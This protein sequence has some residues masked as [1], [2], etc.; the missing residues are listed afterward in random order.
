MDEWAHSVHL[1][2]GVEKHAGF[3]LRACVCCMAVLNVISV[4]A[5]GS[6]GGGHPP[7]PAT[8]S[9]GGS[10]TKTRIQPPPTSVVSTDTWLWS[11]KHAQLCLYIQCDFMAK[12]RGVPQGSV[13]FPFSFSPS[14]PSLVSLYF[15][16]TRCPRTNRWSKVMSP[17][18]QR[19][20]PAWWQTSPPGAPLT[21]QHWPY[22]AGST[23]Q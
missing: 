11:Q 22:N 21:K 3:P 5:A 23:W 18:H 4:W 19:C 12:P 7:V 20:R 17:A 8:H 1:V 15:S 6:D 9:R 14:S 10:K 16:L 13:L 2:R